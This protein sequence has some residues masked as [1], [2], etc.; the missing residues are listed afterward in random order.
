MGRPAHCGNDDLL[1]RDAESRRQAPVA[2]VAGVFE[3]RDIRHA[4]IQS[5]LNRAMMKVISIREIS[6]QFAFR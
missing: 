5:E 4:A 6:L 3:V 2:A 1:Q